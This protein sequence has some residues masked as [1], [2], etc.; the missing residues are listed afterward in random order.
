MLEGTCG[1][2]RSACCVP[3][4]PS[5]DRA[6]S[7]TFCEPLVEGMKLCRASFGGVGE[8][9]AP[10]LYR[11]QA[12]MPVHHDVGHVGCRCS[13]GIRERR[14]GRDGGMKYG[15]NLEMSRAVNVRSPHRA[16]DAE[17]GPCSKSRCCD[18]MLHF[19]LLSKP[20]Q[21]FPLFG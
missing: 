9:A 10:G 13:R 12:G 17:C 1:S 2:V 7:P 14:C 6:V 21:T 3:P 20:R 8:Q 5:T 4:L 19:I 18:C 11:I 16:F 15:R